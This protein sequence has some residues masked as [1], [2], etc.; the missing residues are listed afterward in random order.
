LIHGIYPELAFS[1]I[2]FGIILIRLRVEKRGAGLYS[3]RFI[4]NYPGSLAIWEGTG[5]VVVEL[6]LEVK[7]L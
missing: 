5:G 2:N 6:F 3:L 4:R 7:F 1:V